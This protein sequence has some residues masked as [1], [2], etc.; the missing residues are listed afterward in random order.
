MLEPD[1]AVERIRTAFHAPDGYRS[2]HARG[3]FFVGTFTATPEAA[4]LCRAGHLSGESVPVTVRWSNA[5]GSPVI[6]D[7]HPDIR[8][9][10]ISFQLPD[11][12][13]TD[14]L[15]QTSPR[16]PVRNVDDFV[17]LAEARRRPLTLPLFLVRHPRMVPGLLA[18]MR[19]RAAAAHTSYAEMAYYP[20]HA[21]R[22]L[23]ADDRPSWVR[24]T[25]IPVATSADRLEER[26][27]GVDRLRDEMDARLAR[28]PVAYDVRVQV[29]GPRD[30]PHDPTSVWRGERELLAGRVSVTTAMP[31]ASHGG[32][33]MIGHQIAARIAPPPVPTSPPIN[34]Q[35]SKATVA[36][37]TN[38]PARQDRKATNQPRA[39]LTAPAATPRATTS[40]P[41]PPKAMMRGPS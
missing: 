5:A 25:F 4:E 14:L 11:G 1:A 17:A 30:D 18:G 35:A 16:V 10:A 13:T 7:Q 36:V 27:A 33:P 32:R 40:A 8:G 34:R 31:R 9:M 41:L 3:G 19:A 37:P 26:F 29:A 12:T 2:L 24:Y 21:Y 6:G 22:W 39:A 28:G 15:G 38:P 23:G 20:I